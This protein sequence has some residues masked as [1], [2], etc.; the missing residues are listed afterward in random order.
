MIAVVAAALAGTAVEEV[1]AAAGGRSAVV[2]CAPVGRALHVASTFPLPGDALA[3]LEENPAGRAV[4]ALRDP[5]AAEAA[6]VDLAGTIVTSF[7]KGDDG[8]TEV[9]VPFSGSPAQA[10][11][12]LA[13][14]GAKVT[15]EPGGWLLDGEKVDLHATLA[16]GRLVL[17]GDA[18]TPA[19]PA[20][21][22]PLLAGLPA[23][24]GCVVW[25]DEPDGDKRMHA[26]AFVP[27]SGKAPAVVRLE[28]PEPVADSLTRPPV[29]PANG[30]SVQ[31]PTFVATI[32]IPA[33]D[34][35]A[36]VA[37]VA[38]LPP[39]ELAKLREV[40]RFGAGATVALFGNPREQVFVARLPVTDPG[41]RPMPAKK[42]AALAR[43]MAA[44]MGDVSKSSP[45]SFR[46]VTERSVFHVAA[47][48]GAIV[49]GSVPEAVAEAASGAGTPWLDADAAAWAKDWTVGLV[50]L[51]LPMRAGVLLAPER[52]E[53]QMSVA[54]LPPELTASMAGA[55]AAMAV[56]NFVQMQRKAK[57]S[58]VPANLAAIAVAE[59]A[60]FAANDRYVA[61]PRA[62]AALGKEA[63][64]WVGGPEWTQLAWSPE[65]EV[66]GS[67]W[68][69]LVGDGFVVHGAI[70]VDGDGVPAEYTLGH[71]GGEPVRVTPENVY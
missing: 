32:G 16:A 48:Q 17:R 52:A 4:L 27:L 57:R 10:E 14:F 34:L 55:M 9:V 47:E 23:V 19:T 36:A 63:V 66:R 59:R 6:G 13:R 8:A 40:V 7:R 53:V 42:T 64:P 65:G 18:A 70:D 60:H 49:I 71:D 35:L 5:A 45:T 44:A 15:P 26:A 21:P 38:K 30:S 41:G 67:Y 68:V 33:D 24:D 58:E 20:A 2:A 28:Y 11:A 3:K 39:E 22:D 29:K 43:K 62:V 31:V 1:A 37:P 46:V 50:G 56:P 25:V 51:Q 61:V 69:E 54:P 12:L